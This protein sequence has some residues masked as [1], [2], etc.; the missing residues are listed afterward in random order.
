[1]SKS[2]QVLPR[3][4]P[5]LQ[6]PA[7]S[8]NLLISASLKLQQLKPTLSITP[9]LRKDPQSPQSPESVQDDSRNQQRHLWKIESEN[10]HSDATRIS[11]PALELL[12]LDIPKKA[13]MMTSLL[14]SKLEIA[15]IDHIA[16]KTLLLASQCLTIYFCI[17][18]TVF[19]LTW[20]NMQEICHGKA[21][22]AAKYCEF[23]CSSSEE[24]CSLALSS[25]ACCTAESSLKK[26]LVA[27]VGNC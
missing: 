23:S 22:K 2:R 16:L 18:G 21:G 1:M 9:C 12:L 5:K 26:Q 15:L 4:E 6:K 17:V 8:L 24:P 19:G 11:S 14:I 27:T 3:L 13:R 25:E 10:R 7:P 20:Y